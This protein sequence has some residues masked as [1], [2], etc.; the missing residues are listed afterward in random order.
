MQAEGEVEILPE[1]IVD[2][3][4]ASRGTS[5]SYPWY[6]NYTAELKSMFSLRPWLT[7]LGDSAQGCRFE[8]VCLDLIVPESDK[9]GM[10]DLVVGMS[11]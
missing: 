8:G 3:H 4:G 5:S 1:G 7:L 2:S 9:F 11:S 6:H 10:S